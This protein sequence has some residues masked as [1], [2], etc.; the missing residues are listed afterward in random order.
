MDIKQSWHGHQME[1]IEKTIRRQ[2]EELDTKIKKLSSRPLPGNAKPEYIDLLCDQINNTVADMSVFGGDIDK[3]ENQIIDKRIALGRAKGSLEVA[4]ASALAFP[5]PSADLSNDAKR[6]AYVK[7]KTQEQAQ[8]IISL[9]S[10][11][12]ELQGKKLE[13]Q[14]KYESSQNKYLA[15]KAQLENSSALLNYFSKS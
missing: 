3:I 9:E 8:I 6:K 5:D 4:E 11:I 12:F 2:F 15:T 13:V 7:A 10:D 14:R 1:D